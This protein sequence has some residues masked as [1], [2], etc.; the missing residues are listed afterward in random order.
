MLPKRLDMRNLKLCLKYYTPTLLYVRLVGSM[1]GTVKVSEHIKGR[2]LTF[3]KEKSG[4]RM[5]V[6]GNEV[7]H[8]S[9]KEHDKGFVLAYERFVQTGVHTGGM[10]HLSHGVDPYDPDLPEP[11]RSLLRII[12]DDHLMEISFAGRVHLK[13]HSWL[14]EPYWKY[15]TTCK[16]PRQSKKKE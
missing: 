15:W 3:R 10:L 14:K 7:F 13:F 5:F 16:P 9:P 8:F 12:L 1:G 6:D 2:S 4:L 11:T